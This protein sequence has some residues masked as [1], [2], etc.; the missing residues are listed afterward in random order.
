MLSKELT[1]L[2][3]LNYTTEPTLALGLTGITQLKTVTFKSRFTG[4]KKFIIDRD[5]N[6]LPKI[7]PTSRYKKSQ[8]GSSSR[9]YTVNK[10]RVRHTILNWINSQKGT[11]QL[12][13]FTLTFPPCITDN[14]AYSLLNSW[15]T[16]MRTSAHLRNYL[17]VAERQQ[18]STIHFHIA[19]SER[20]NIT[21]A[22]SVMRNLLHYSIRKQKLNWSHSSAARYN[23]VDIAKNR[24]TRRVTNFASGKSQR[25]LS[26][27]LTKYMSKA[28]TKFKRQAWQCSKSLSAL[29]THYTMTVDEFTDRFLN[30]ID[31]NECLIQCDTYNFF[32]WA[33]SPPPELKQLLHHINNL[34]L[35][36]S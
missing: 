17:W 12:Y 33:N 35:Q 10:K 11:K 9:F 25:N 18:N 14:L 13:F 3:K 15:L 21:F 28:D 19:L 31:Q 1:N 24:K 29:F 8:P 36:H 34:N 20:L 23:G 27:Y 7:R 26:S 22:N 30:Y 32:R 6:P 2:T 16:T 5:G 4:S